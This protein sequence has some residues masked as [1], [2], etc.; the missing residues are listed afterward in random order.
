MRTLFFLLLLSPWTSLLAQVSFSAGT[1]FI[2]GL[3]TERK[4]YGAHIGFELP[5]S[6]DLTFFLRGYAFLPYNEKDT[7]YANMT[8]LDLSTTPYT[9]TVP[10]TQK[11]NCFYVEGGTRSYMLS[12]Y[13]NG[14][15]LYGGSI[16][17]FGIN[18]TSAKFSRYDYTNTYEWEGKYQLSNGANT[19]TKGSIYYLALGLQGGMKYTIPIRGTIYFDVTGTYSILNV[20]NNAA[21]EN[22]MT[23]SRINFLVQLGYRKDLY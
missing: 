12:D 23:Y 2:S 7:N 18:T 1:G 15:S 8:A 5:R 16:F 10:F 22:S 17:G 13:D 21:A 20:A 14:F 3:G 9:I 11:S 6:S 19:P 4:S